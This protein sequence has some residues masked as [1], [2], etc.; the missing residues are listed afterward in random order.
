MSSDMKYPD[1]G[2]KHPV[3]GFPQVTFI[4]NFNENP[5]V[6]IGDYTYYD[7]PSGPENF[8]ENILYHFNFYRR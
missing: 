2:T 8:F 7:D 4:K 1:P 6:I 5:N 3:A